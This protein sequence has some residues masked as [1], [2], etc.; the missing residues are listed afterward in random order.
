MR[1][2][3]RYAAR[4][5]PL[6]FSL[7]PGGLHRR[8][9]ALEPNSHTRVG[10]WQETHACYIALVYMYRILPNTPPK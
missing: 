3:G 6:P 1:R 2:A 7:A 5:R 9:L 10:R 8:C 4:G